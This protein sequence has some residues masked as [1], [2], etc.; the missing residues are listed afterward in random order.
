MHETKAILVRDLGVSQLGK[1]CLGIQAKNPKTTADM[2]TTKP[3]GT[4]HPTFEHLKC[5]DAV[6]SDSC[7][8]FALDLPWTCRL[9]VSLKYF[10]CE[11]RRLGL[12]R[13]LAGPADNYRSAFGAATPTFCLTHLNP[14][15]SPTSI[16]FTLILLLCDIPRP[17][18]LLGIQ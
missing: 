13:C 7:L 11:R 2:L 17:A 6:A 8:E 9:V 3:P 14:L 12:A 15:L 16:S 18:A 10:I 4:A 1:W 5:C